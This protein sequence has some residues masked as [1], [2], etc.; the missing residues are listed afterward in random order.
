M[1]TASP[2]PE[3]EKVGIDEPGIA[4]VDPDGEVVAFFGKASTRG[5]GLPG[6]A[7]VD[8]LP[9]AVTTAP[10]RAEMDAHP[11]E[12]I[13]AYAEDRTPVYKTP[14]DVRPMPST[15]DQR[16]NRERKQ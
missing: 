3:S 4:L 10:E 12:R 8:E 13:K 2:S 5:K 14:A 16:T 15:K 11:E 6:A 9:H 7:D 1:R